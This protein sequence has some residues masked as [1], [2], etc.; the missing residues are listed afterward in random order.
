MTWNVI[1]KYSVIR[2]KSLYTGTPD[3]EFNYLD[4]IVDF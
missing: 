2:F 1:Y 4:T 3:L